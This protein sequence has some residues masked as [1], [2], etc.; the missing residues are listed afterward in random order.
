M[1][2]VCGKLDFG[3]NAISEELLR[4]MCKSIHYRGPD[5]EGIMIDR[6]PDGGWIGLGH[7]RLSIIDLSSSGHQPMCNE[8]GSLWITYNGEIYNF[9][10]LKEELEKRG[11]KFKSRTDTEVILHLY[12]EQGVDAVNRLNGMFAFAIWDRNR[13]QLWVCR[14]RIGIKP[15]VYYWDGERF[16]FGSEIK[17]LL[18]NPEIKKEIDP[19]ALYLYLTFSYVPAPYTIFK[20]IRKLEPGSYLIIKDKN[21]YQERYWNI[22]D[23]GCI[24]KR[25]KNNLKKR[26]FETLRDSVIKRLIADV[27]VGAFLSGGIDSSIVVALMARYG[28]GNVKTFSIGF[29]DLKFFDE[30][31][32]SREIADRY[33]TDHHE[34]TLTSK[35]MLDYMEEIL[36]CFDEPFSDSS[37]IP[38]F[39]ISKETR[40][41]VKV[42]LSGDGGDELFAGYRSYL[43]EYWLRIYRLIPFV[44]RRSFIE[45]IILKL[46]DSRDIQF[47][48]YIRRAKKFVR[49][50]NGSLTER[51]LSLREI[52]PKD[53]RE[54][55]LNPSL[56]GDNPFIYDIP[57]R[58]IRSRLSEHKTDPINQLLYADLKDPLPC[59]MLTK[60]DWMSMKNSLEVRVPFLDHRVVE[61]AFEIPGSLK[62]HRGR[63]KHILIDTFKELLPKSIIKRGKAG[64]EIPISL[65]LKRELRFLI[66]RYLNEKFIDEQGIFNYKA[67]EQI[68]ELFFKRR[69]DA[70]WML[71]NLIVFQFWY[72]KYLQ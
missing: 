34:I 58:W 51:F 63:G 47:L 41:Y 23:T 15:L 7:R 37:A 72:G 8:D 45:K 38:M 49:A 21:L 57:L 44:F 12:E 31:R 28:N 39:I 19:Q 1:C 27:P 32:Y 11:H 52:F 65:W 56:L 54:K 25:D 29:K 18:I 70:S 9:Y 67:I 40:K 5:N 26:L 62:I 69:M 43:S 64:F 17:S 30:T 20:G 33:N 4:K 68:K 13:S 66:D 24:N 59:D 10:E 22:R 36:S 42:A 61:L 50:S 60:V 48:E 55:L 53:K 14:D 46:P 3:E 16:I 71:W 35:V 2:G 6:I